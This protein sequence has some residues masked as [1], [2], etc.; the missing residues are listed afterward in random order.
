MDRF[1][2]VPAQLF[3]GE[4]Y[5]KKE[6]NVK[7]YEGENKVPYFFTYINIISQVYFIGPTKYKSY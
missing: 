3:D 5:V 2:Y 4:S 7:I 6:S 1:E